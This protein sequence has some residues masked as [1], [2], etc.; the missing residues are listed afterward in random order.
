MPLIFL[1]SITA[2][3]GSAARAAVTTA[4]PETQV[5]TYEIPDPEYDQ[6]S[7]QFTFSDKAG[8][9]WIGNIDPVTGEFQPPDGQSILVDTD[10]AYVT[11]FGN[12]PEWLRSAQGLQ[13][14]YTKYL[15]NH[16]HR[17]RYAGIGRAKMTNGLW[18]GD[19]LDSGGQ[20]HS[21]M[22]SLDKEDPNPRIN[23]QGVSTKTF[24]WRALDNPATEELVPNSDQSGGARRWVEGVNAMI[25]T[26]DTID[27]LGAVVSQVFLYNADTKI[28]EQL[29]H[30]S[31]SK[32]GAFMWRAP[33]YANEY[34]FFTIIDRTQLRVYRKVDVDGDGR[35]KWTTVKI[36]PA[37]ETLPYIWSPEPFVYKGRSFIF[38]QLSSSRYVNDMGV[39]TQLGMTGVDPANNNFRMLTDD[40]NVRRV[41][42]DPE[43]FITA[44]GPYIY[45]NRYLPATSTRPPS[46]EGIWRVDTGLGPPPTPECVP[47]PRCTLLRIDTVLA[48][49]AVAA[50]T[51]FDRPCDHARTKATQRASRNGR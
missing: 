1:L 27:P 34:V 30:D 21:P 39:P 15:A 17:S 41:R 5:S 20:R 26:A 46:P 43:V 42:M 24:Y 12:G 48:E 33:E 16:P 28:L 50:T 49:D 35:L 10:V 4:L 38:M 40:A 19:F 13:I 31:G 7:A 51:P 23:Y 37:P 3:Q 22:A 44:Q 6:D 18:S 45:Y 11:D 2:P 29:T 9:L 32:L 36:I 47:G 14:V 8:N 25:F